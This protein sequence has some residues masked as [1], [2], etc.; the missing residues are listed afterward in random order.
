[1]KANQAPATSSSEKEYGRTANILLA[2]G[3]VALAISILAYFA[4]LSSLGLSNLS[5]DWGTFG[6]FV[7]GIA[8]TAIS[9]V[10]LWAIAS[11]LKLQAKEL[12]ET[13]QHLQDQALTMERE[14]IESTVFRLLAN[15]RGSVAGFIVNGQVG[16]QAIHYCATQ[17]AQR[18]QNFYANPP[19]AGGAAS[20]ATTVDVFLSQNRDL[21]PVI[22][23]TAQLL[24]YA[25]AHESE[26]DRLSLLTLA[27]ADLTLAENVLL[28]YVG[29]SNYGK[30]FDLFD[31]FR[32]ADLFRGISENEFI[33]AIAP[34]V[35]ERYQ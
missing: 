7:G 17:L 30:R 25:L 11:T 8:G 32:D 28:L 18:V 10:T 15:R 21:D 24:K 35:L 13:K 16:R 2:A 22:G 29:I 3:C 6:D 1:V 31:T 9:L 26:N 23:S 5:S 27:R 14:N 19:A 20:L 34:E 4:G 12:A 33:V